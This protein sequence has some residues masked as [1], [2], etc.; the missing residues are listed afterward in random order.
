MTPL[1]IRA[2][3]SVRIGTGHVMRCLALA[4]AWQDGGGEAHFAL[5]D[6]PPAAAGRLEAEGLR[7]HRVAADAGGAEDAREV[8]RLARRVGAAWLVLDGYHFPAQYQE[9]VKGSGLRLLVIDDYGHAGRYAADLILNQNL[10]AEGRLY[11]GRAPGSRL[12]LGPRYALLRREFLKWSGWK[13]SVPEVARTALVTLGGA[14]AGNVTGQVLRALRA[15][16]QGPFEA[17]VL[18]GP[19]NPNRRELEEAV[20][21]DR[22]VSL[23]VNAP[24]VARLMAWADVAVSAA[25][26]TCYEL[27]FMGLPALALVLADNQ[28]PVAD[29]LERHGL[30]ESAG[31]GDRLD[32]GAM[33]DLLSAFLNDSRRRSAMAERGRAW[34]DGRGGGRVAALLGLEQERHV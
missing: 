6:A 1:L 11:E 2:D 23:A 34:V 31:W 32:V 21:G 14:D 24:D 25:G 13:R 15:I 16:R 22:R 26:S 30:G 7:L 9:A 4:Q 3:A 19:G 29:A 27:L 28:A 18:V 12:L 17:V 5:A 33:A 8:V 10:Y 20:R